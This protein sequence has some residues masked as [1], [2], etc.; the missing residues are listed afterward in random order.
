MLR[1]QVQRPIDVPESLYG[2][3]ISRKHSLKKED[4][5]VAD[6]IAQALKWRHGLSIPLIVYHGTMPLVVLT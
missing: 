2:R 3:I 5:V 1:Y 4:L 6:R